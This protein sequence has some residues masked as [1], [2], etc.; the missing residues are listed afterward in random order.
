MVNWPQLRINKQERQL[1]AA[2]EEFNEFKVKVA[3][4]LLKMSER[5]DVI[6]GMNA[7]RRPNA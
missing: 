2:V 5:L 1:A 6:E 7:E 3:A 4:D